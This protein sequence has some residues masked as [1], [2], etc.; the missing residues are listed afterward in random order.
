[1]II[2]KCLD[3]SHRGNRSVTPEIVL[4]GKREIEYL[5]PNISFKGSRTPPPRSRMDTAPDFMRGQNRPMLKN[6]TK[7]LPDNYPD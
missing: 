2:D 3:E 5:P 7:K 4:S 6:K 1:M